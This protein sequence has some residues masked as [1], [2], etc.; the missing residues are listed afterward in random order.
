MASEGGRML[1]HVHTYSDRDPADEFEGL[2][3][4]VGNHEF[5]CD[6]L[7]VQQ[8]RVQLQPLCESAEPFSHRF[9]EVGRRETHSQPDLPIDGESLII[10]T[11]KRRERRQ[12]R[13]TANLCKSKACNCDN[14][15]PNDASPVPDNGAGGSPIDSSA[16]SFVM[17]PEVWKLLSE[18]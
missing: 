7:E 5:A 13:K 9:D 15:E 2:R 3:L 4:G 17:T 6:D 11:R 14:H 12:R 8:L 1:P 18:S 10:A 16:S